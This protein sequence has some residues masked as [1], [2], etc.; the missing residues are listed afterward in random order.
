MASDRKIAANRRNARQSTGPRSRLGKKHA[1][2]NAYRHGLT[3][4]VPSTS[5]EKRLERL[6]RRI[7][8]RSQDEALLSF[9]RTAAEA[10]LELR[11]VR[12]V[13]ISLIERAI[14]LGDLNAPKHFRS[15]NQEVRWLIAMDLY[16]MGKRRVP[17]P[18]PDLI[19][20][21]ENMPKELAERLAEAVR[22]ILPGLV[23]IDRYERRAANRRDR[24]IR[25]ILEMR[26]LER[27]KQEADLR[28]D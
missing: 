28:S 19:N 3:L 23:V 1:S 25:Q 2:R 21:A 8:G 11:R 18:Q 16:N 17:P 10:E 24:A 14:E 26:T 20:P 12:N 4:R 15:T 13:R 27:K 7:A 9:A 5:L 6:A 22:R